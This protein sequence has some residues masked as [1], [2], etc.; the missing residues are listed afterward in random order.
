MSPEIYGRW[1]KH[2]KKEPALPS[3]QQ[4]TGSWYH[5]CLTLSSCCL[6]KCY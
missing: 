6:L 2:W 5:L 4:H 1:E 3:L